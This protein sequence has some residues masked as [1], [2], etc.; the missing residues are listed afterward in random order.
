MYYFLLLVFGL[1][2]RLLVFF[3]KILTDWWQPVFNGWLW[4]ILG[5]IFAPITLLWYSV[6]INWFYGQWGTWQIVVLAF[7]VIVDLF[8][9]SRFAKINEE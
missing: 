4:I 9:L 5:I 8:S 1:F 3:L 6:I 7:T 2:P